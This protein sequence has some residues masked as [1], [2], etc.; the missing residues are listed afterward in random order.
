MSD[1]Q[2]SLKNILAIRLLTLDLPQLKSLLPEDKKK[3]KTLSSSYSWK[4]LCFKLHNPYSHKATLLFHN[5]YP[6]VPDTSCI[7]T[8][9]LLKCTK[10]HTH[11]NALTRT[12]TDRISWL[13]SQ[14]N[15]GEE[16]NDSSE[17]QTTN[18]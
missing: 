11:L 4:L 15:D 13:T 10:E 6:A 9:H 14:Q 3:K 2:R 12:F 16:H 1:Q 8:A 7:T 18:T 5:V 17:D